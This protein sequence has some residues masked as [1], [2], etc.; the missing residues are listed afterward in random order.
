MS[1][2]SRTARFAIR[3]EQSQVSESPWDGQGESMQINQQWN[4][5]DVSFSSCLRFTPDALAAHQNRRTDMVR[6]GTSYI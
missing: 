3:P 6:P 4:D 5:L 2:W 1:L